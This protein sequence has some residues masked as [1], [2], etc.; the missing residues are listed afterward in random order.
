MNEA[1]KA[2]LLANSQART[3]LYDLESQPE[4]DSAAIEKAAKEYRSTE[5]AVRT[6]LSAEDGD[7]TET[8]V[9]G[10][11]RERR[12]VRS[13]ARLAEYVTHAITGTTQA[14]AE[15]ELTAAYGCKPG[16]MPFAMLAPVEGDARREIRAVTPGPAAPQGTQAPIPY[17]FSRT[18]AAA[19]GVTFPTVAAGEKYYPLLSTA[20]PASF[21]A[22][23]GAALSTASAF[24]LA[25][26][27]PK[28]VTGQ[29]T[30]RVEDLAVMPS[31][32]DSLGG[33]IGEAIAVA[34]DEQVMT[35]NGSG[36]NLTGLFDIATDVAIE[37]ATE[38]YATGVARFAALVDGRYANSMADLRAV[39]GTDTYAAYASLFRNGS[40]GNLFDYLMGKLGGLFVSTHVPNKTGMGQKGIVMRTRGSQIA[41]VPVWSGLTLIRDPYTDAGKG[42]ITVTAHALVGNPHL[43]YGTSSV[44]EIH[45]K[46]S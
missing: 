3:A 36:A 30:V 45:P 31:I 40:D 10:E 20:P 14:G 46:I 42:Q 12:E 2:A 8:T 29:F 41:E 39:I 35:G 33:A 25:S 32:E 5:E 28:R 15:A 16:Q 13:R 26:R 22:K 34:T 23:D 21:K 18:A 27:T 44:V 9:D 24:T 38:T 19:L 37:T 6:A 1:Q 4:P 43:P 11:D 17:V 7:V